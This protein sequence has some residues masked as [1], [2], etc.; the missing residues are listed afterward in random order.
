M[1]RFTRREGGGRGT[2]DRAG[3]AGSAT[4]AEAAT[5][6]TRRGCLEPCW[7]LCWLP[8]CLPPGVAMK[9]LL[10][11]A[12]ETPPVL[13]AWLASLAAGSRPCIVIAAAGVWGVRPGAAGGLCAGVWWL[14]VLRPVSTGTPAVPGSGQAARERRG[15]STVLEGPRSAV[16]GKGVPLGF[17]QISC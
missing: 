12:L 10:L 15:V 1:L 6:C 11:A 9:A 3:A 13:A 5:A 4:A 7:T 17:A 8:L 14:R 16:A 2:G